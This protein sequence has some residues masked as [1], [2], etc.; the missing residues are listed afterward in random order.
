MKKI[1]I[2]VVEDEP[3]L[4]QTIS[5]FL[6]IQNYEVE[7]ALTGNKALE[8]FCQ[9]KQKVDLILLD[10]MLPDISGYTVLK[11]IR[12]ISEVPVIILSARSAVADQMSGFEKGADDYITKPFT[13]ALVKMHIEAVLKRA[14]KLR[15][16]VEYNDLQADV[17]AQLLFYKEQHIP[18]TRKEFDLMVYFMEHPGI[19]LPRDT[20]LNAVW[21]YDYTGDVRTIDTLVKQLRK[22]WEKAAIISG[23]FTALA[24]SS[25]RTS[26]KIKKDFWRDGKALWIQIIAFAVAV[27]LYSVCCYPI[28]TSSKARI[29]RQLYEDI[30][31][32]DLEE[33]SEDDEETLGDYQKE[34]FETVIANENYEQIYTSRSSLKTTHARKY[35]ENKI[36][37]YTEEGTLEQ[38][39]MESRHIL[40]FR[41]KIIQ[42]G[43]TFY[44]YLRKDVQSVLEVIEG[45]RLYLAI[46]LLLMVG[47]SYFLEKKS[48]ASTEKKAK[49]SDYQLLES[50]REFVANISH[51]LKT[52]LAVVSSQV[53]M[54]E[55]AGD[56]IDRSYYYSS[57]HEELDKMSRMVGELL[58]FSMLDN[59][60]SSM[61]MSRVN[62]SEMIEYLLLR[63]DAMF[64]KNEIK[65]EQEIEK[66][67]FAYGN[68][69]YLERAVNNY[70]MNA[71]QHT[72]Q[73]KRIRITLKKEKKQI[74]MEVYNDGE[75]IKEEQM[76]HIWDSFY[77]TSQKKKPVTSENEVRNIGLGLFVVRKIVNKH[78]G[79][80]GVQ[81]MEN[82]VLFWL[83][84][85]EIRDLGK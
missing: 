55:I 1:E 84:L 31:D 79:S 83:Q 24:T 6:R 80:C 28:Y 25:G 49:Q 10:L 20:I 82:G 44:V 48:K 38:R 63:Y 22:K 11:E 7:T 27:M 76:E 66:N 81:N 8:Y 47:L 57:I 51:E 13:L 32:M 59:Q 39:R 71:F 62:V 43:H 60:M 45:T 56:K 18:T 77:T 5:D 23:L 75:R 14:G 29:M 26:M 3:K 72:E 40:M 58:D 69:M 61:E 52:P 19:V 2:L 37:Q 35:I 12:K 54:L 15:T 70:L 33:L 30:H 78:K 67:C 36:A 16:M 42:D 4:A 53:E 64:R 73:G 34:K 65:V 50:Q 9:N 46:V 85:P 74:R 68:R 17:N 21:E 41:G